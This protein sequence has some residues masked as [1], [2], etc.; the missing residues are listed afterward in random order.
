M[1]PTEYYNKGKQKAESQLQMLKKQIGLNSILRLISFILV[2]VVLFTFLKIQTQLAVGGS[3]LFLI[4]FLVL[5]K[6][7]V[8]LG[9]TRSYYQQ[10]LEITNNELDALSNDFR[11]F[12]KGEKY[13]NHNHSYSFDLDLFGKGS[14]FEMLNRSTTE[15]GEQ[16]LAY[17]LLNEPASS[18]E[19][20]LLQDGVKELSENPD[21]MMNFRAIGMMSGIVNED[22]EL[23][24]QWQNSMSFVNARKALRFLTFFLPT[25]LIITLAGT[26]INQDLSPLFISVF[27][28]NF[29]FVGFNIKK[30]NKE[31]SQVSRL[32]KMLLKYQK[33][34]VEIEKQDF[35]A[36][37][38]VKSQ[39]NLKHKEKT[40]SRLL[41]ELTKIVGGFDNR[42]NFV[43]AIFLEGFLVWDYHC[44]FKLEYWR[45]ENGRLLT[46]WINEIA[47]FDSLISGGTFVFNNPE[48]MYPKVSEAKLLESLALGHPL[49]PSSVRVSNDF[50]IKNKGDFTIITGANMAGKSTFLRTVGI[51]LVLAKSGLPVCAKS[52]EFSNLTLFTSMRTSDSL[53]ENESYFYAELK[54]LKSV[55]D[56]LESGENLFIIL[57]EIL[58][59]TN[60]VDKQ[61]GSRHALEKI[62]KLG[63]TGIIATHDL[64][65][66]EIS[67]THSEKVK[68]QC[69]EIEIDNAKIF[70][71]YKLYNGVTQKMNA[72]LLMEQMGII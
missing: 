67:K 5:V 14:L 36:E 20:Y 19:I 26:I 6:R 15:A 32:L 58:K 62:L 16:K 9:K 10:I 65:L 34:L 13:I 28:F 1:K 48:Y 27:I 46:D 12:N 44:L 23:I 11:A 2:F 3:I 7:H 31:H 70:F 47:F 56:K 21:F 72:M 45:T 43:A 50:S 60:S 71:D 61:N 54:R 59:G 64:A 8:E 38:L 30:I 35:N 18:E 53:S 4:G 24:K 25:V 69:F 57:D 42:L 55:M 17:R 41:G 49:I 51:N 33:L 40:A 63:G 52:F 68:N 66:T 39:D 37:L 22:F 29:F